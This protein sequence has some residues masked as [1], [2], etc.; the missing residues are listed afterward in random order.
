MAGLDHFHAKIRKMF[1]HAMSCCN[2]EEEN[3]EWRPV[4]VSISLLL[5]SAISSEPGF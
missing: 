3:E 1:K 5:L 4:I 2:Q